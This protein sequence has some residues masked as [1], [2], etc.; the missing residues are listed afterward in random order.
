[1]YVKFGLKPRTTLILCETLKLRVKVDRLVN[2]EKNLTNEIEQLKAS[3]EQM[4]ASNEQL[5]TS[6]VALKAKVDR[7]EVYL[8]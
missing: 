8:L 7:L 5:K 4:K 1:M 3:N 2:L 6:N